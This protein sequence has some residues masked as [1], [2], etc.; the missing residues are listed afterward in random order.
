MFYIPITTYFRFWIPRAARISSS[1]PSCHILLFLYSLA[2]PLSSFNPL[3]LLSVQFWVHPYKEY[4][5]PRGGLFNLVIC[6]PYFLEILGLTL[7]HF[8]DIVCFLLHFGINS[9]ATRKCHLSQVR[10]F[11]QGC[12]R[13]HSFQFFKISD[14]LLEK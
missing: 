3:T 9:V 8:S 1:T 11:S 12:Q 7:L 2:H 5:I 14:T 13:S 6:P 10:R 4:K